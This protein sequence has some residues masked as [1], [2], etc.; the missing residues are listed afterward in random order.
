MPLLSDGLNELRS[1]WR[2]RRRDHRN[3]LDRRWPSGRLDFDLLL[4]QAEAE[5]DLL[6]K[7]NV[8]E[9]L[10]GVQ[11]PG[12][13]RRMLEIGLA[14]SPAG[15]APSLVLSLAANHPDLVWYPRYCIFTRPQ[16]P[17]NAGGW[18]SRSMS[19]EVK[20]RSNAGRTK[21]TKSR[22]R[23]RT[24]AGYSTARLAPRS[25][26]IHTCGA[27]HAGHNAMAS[28]GTTQ[29]CQTLSAASHSLFSVARPMSRC[30]HDLSRRAVRR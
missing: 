28:A 9:A 13:A 29:Q 20:V 1:P 10:A 4:A 30:S 25:D 21:P 18:K 16:L 23:R 15:M 12:L 14:T 27:R 26:E 8:F 22:C 19:P 6:S 5:Q 2:L 3:V 11:D 17:R 7:Q 24:R